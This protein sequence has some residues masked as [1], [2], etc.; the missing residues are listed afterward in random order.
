[1]VVGYEYIFFFAD[2]RNDGTQRK[3]LRNYAIR[4]IRNAGEIG[5]GTVR[6][7]RSLLH[8]PSSLEN[9]AYGTL[10]YTAKKRII[11]PS[12]KVKKPVRSN[13]IKK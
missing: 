6:T 9:I 10:L 2:L 13:K 11:K 7:K 3:C 5:Q 12:N 1:M 8:I 4:G